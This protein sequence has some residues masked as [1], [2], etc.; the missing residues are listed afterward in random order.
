MATHYQ[1][2]QWRKRLERKGWIGLKRRQADR[3]RWIEFHVIWQGWLYS[4]RCKL[5]LCDEQDHYRP[6][7]TLYMLHRQKDIADGV[8]R[9]SRPGEPGMV[10][11]QWV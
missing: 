9:Y 8:W 4:G 7:T 1:V 2:T 10:R 3:F 5:S 6:G 11:R